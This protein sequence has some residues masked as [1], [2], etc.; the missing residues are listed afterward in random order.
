MEDFLSG[1]SAVA[2]AAIALFFL[3][4]W[5][6]TGDRFFVLFAIAF[7]IFAVNRCVL[8][9]LDD[10]DEARTVVYVVRALAFGVII[11][12]IVDKNRPVSRQ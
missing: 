9:A 11:V 3:R 4:F 2:A 8:A 7:A 12:A 1:A 6:E 5:R 10:E